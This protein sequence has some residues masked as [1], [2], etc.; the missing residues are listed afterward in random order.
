MYYLSYVELSGFH[1]ALMLTKQGTPESPAIILCEAGFG[2]DVDSDEV[3]LFNI[4]KGNLS[5]EAN[6]SRLL[7][8]NSAVL[9]HKTFPISEIEVNKFFTILNRDMKAKV[10]KEIKNNKEVSQAN[11]PDYQKT[12][13]NCK[14]YALKVLK[15]IGIVDANQL[16]NFWIQ[17]PGTME[18]GLE[19]ISKDN[20]ECPLKDNFIRDL[21]NLVERLHEH[22]DKLE[23]LQDNFKK[24]LKINR[25]FE[26]VTDMRELSNRLAARAHKAGIEKDFTENFKQ[27]GYYLREFR[28]FKSDI[29]KDKITVKAQKDKILK[30]FADLE[31]IEIKCSR[32]HPKREPK[33]KNLR[34]ILRKISDLSDTNELEFR[35]VK[36]PTVSI[37]L[38][39]QSFSTDE[40]VVYGTTLLRNEANQGLGFILSLLRAEQLKKLAPDFHSD[41]TDLTEIIQS[42]QNELDEIN[43]NFKNSYE[44][45]CKKQ[46]ALIS[47][48]NEIYGNAKKGLEEE[49]QEILK[50]NLTPFGKKF[51]KLSNKE[52]DLEDEIEELSPKVK[53]NENIFNKIKQAFIELY[54]EHVR[55]KTKA[56]LEEIKQ[57]IDKLTDKQITK[58][59]NK[60]QKAIK[61]LSKEKIN[62]LEKNHKIEIKELTELRYEQIEYIKYKYQTED[63]KNKIAECRKKLNGIKQKYQTKLDQSKKTQVSLAEHNQRSTRI[64]LCM[65]QKNIDKFK[66]RTE[67]TTNFF[68][69]FINKILAYFLKDYFGLGNTIK[70]PVA[71]EFEKI[72]HGFKKYMFFRDST[73]EHNIKPNRPIQNRQRRIA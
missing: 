3:G 62:E 22:L 48:Y 63:G 34:D 70:N 66:P 40:K 20:F 19:V 73:N 58:L 49:I 13:L 9:R 54:N 23:K 36:L 2:Y 21:R 32:T 28:T 39:L 30:V 43:E 33:T 59:N 67:E 51:L 25:L 31:S 45:E 53:K 52:I 71:R 26:L 12:G 8:S 14:A 24:S 11:P 1:A 55:I 16:S 61:G 10:T 17:R 69:K 56:Q 7:Y 60:Y 27:F 44:E 37:R 29:K 46:Q 18:N 38:D 65:L 68:L 6:A 64:A 57:E 47:E 50:N 72:Q 41:L 4:V 5:E 35:W 15:E 42:T